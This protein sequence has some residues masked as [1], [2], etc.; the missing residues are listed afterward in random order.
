MDFVRTP[1]ERFS[2]LPD[3]PF[4]PNYVD[5]NGLRMHYVDEGQGPPLLCLHGQPTWS[6]LYRK[7]IPVFVN[8]GY[9]VVAPDFLGFGRS[10]KPTDDAVYTWSFHRNSLLGFIRA[11]NLSR[12]GLVCQDW[13][14]LLGLT[15]PLDVP[16]AIDRLLVMNTAIA[17]GVN[18][19]AG[20]M[21]WKAY[22][23]SRPDLDVAGLLSRSVDGLTEAEAWAYA[24]PFVDQSYKAGVR[25]FP[26][27]VPIEPEME[28]ADE[29]RR[30]MAWWNTAWRGPA[31]MAVGVQDPVLGLRVMEALR[32]TIAG[33]SEPMKIKD[34]GHFVQE[35]GAPIAAAAIAHWAGGG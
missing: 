25:R 16:E 23:A 3:W 14:G 24:A 28:G 17:T 27:L 7:M 6:Y 31:F 33:C 5:L 22:N 10:D 26:E 21:A 12:F 13:G 32:D 9:R 15:L 35:H 11:M 30:A 2:D 8:A 34:G 20:F 19:G 1:D 18:P 29:G 4:A